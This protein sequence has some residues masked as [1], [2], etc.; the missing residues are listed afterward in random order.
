M[1]DQ[2]DYNI[3]LNLGL[4]IGDH[5]PPTKV[6]QKRHKTPCL[7][8]SFALCP[9]QE[10][11]EEVNVKGSNSNIKSSTHEE[12]EEENKR[13]GLI[14]FNDN[15]NISR[16]KL[17]LTKDQSVLLEDSFKLHNTLNPVQKHSL[18]EQLNLTPRQV[19]VWFQNRRA[20]TKLKQTEVDCEFLKKCC[21]SLSDE[22]SRLKKELKELRNVKLGRTP[23]CLHLPICDKI[24]AFGG[25]PHQ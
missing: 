15:D 4:S 5:P 21:E 12:D 1:E 22:N 8:L 20:R 19:E 3:G 17:R 10:E 25:G 6:V 9:K 18:A 7:D 23:L 16:K 24:G 2:G 11:E 13:N 14:R